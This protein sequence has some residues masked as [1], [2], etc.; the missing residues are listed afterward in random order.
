MIPAVH[1]TDRE[2]ASAHFLYG[3]EI[4]EG[5]TCALSISDYGE[6]TPPGFEEWSRGKHALA[7][8]FDDIDRPHRHYVA[9]T[10]LDAVKI[11][12]WARAVNG[13]AIVH[14][15]AG[16]S[17][18]TAAAVAIAACHVT[19]GEEE[20]RII[21]NWIATI[22]PI[23]MPNPLL[24]VYIDRELGWSNRLASARAWRFPRKG[25]IATCPRGHR[26]TR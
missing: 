16:I 7:L 23:A 10:A 24:V 26:I 18:S 17:R 9:P 15:A 8:S 4:G 13:P 11:C 12:A 21:M 14:C 3:S 19:P 6:P 2:T 22:R 25:E 5:V 20:G 1:I